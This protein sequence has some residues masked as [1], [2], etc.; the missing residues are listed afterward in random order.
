ME[1]YEKA[2]TAFIELG[3]YKD[4]KR[5]IA[6]IDS[7]LQCGPACHSQRAG[8]SPALGKRKPAGRRQGRPGGN[9]ESEEQKRFRNGRFCAD[10]ESG[11]AIGKVQSSEC[12]VQRRGIDL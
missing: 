11:G 8:C 3:E 6:E 9:R 10:A 2:L 1:Q 5:K 7:V 12:K 4:S